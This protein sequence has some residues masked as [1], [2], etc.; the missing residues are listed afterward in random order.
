MPLLELVGWIGSAVL[1]ISLL[2]TRVMRFRVLNAVSCVVLVGYNAAVGVWPMVAMNVVLVG[3]NVVVILRLLRQ[4]HDVRAYQAVPIGTDEPFLHAL[5]RRHVSDIAQF[6]PD[7]PADPAGYAEHAFLVSSG[8]QVV[9]VVLS[10][11]GRVPDEQQVVLDYVLPPYRD[12]TPGEFVFRP[13]GPFAA[14]GTR[15]VVAS[16][17]MASAERYLRSV[18]FRLVDGRQVLDLTPA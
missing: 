8:D 1:I 14:L 11:S 15:T 17:G 2:Q 9:G 7:L 4:R 12:A 5:L 10:R 16:P 13:D 18:G 6:N 3:I